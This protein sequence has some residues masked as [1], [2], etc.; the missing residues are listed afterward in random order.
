IVCNTH[1]DVSNT[2]RNRSSAITKRTTRETIRG[3]DVPTIQVHQIL[4][5]TIKAV[6][7]NLLTEGGDILC[8]R[9]HLSEGSCCNTI[10][11]SD[12]TPHRDVSFIEGELH[13]NQ[14]SKSDSVI[15]SA[16]S[17][18]ASAY[19]TMGKAINIV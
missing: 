14:I 17:A 5:V 18:S 9:H 10:N 6:L 4:M 16:T 7:K 8:Q 1:E 19:N 12:T 2:V 13:L 11:D 15:R 3:D